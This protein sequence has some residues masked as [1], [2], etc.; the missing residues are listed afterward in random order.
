MRALALLFVASIFAAPSIAQVKGN[1]NLD[2]SQSGT[3]AVAVGL[4]NTA[5]NTAG[6]I[7]GD[8]RISGNTSIKAAQ[9][10]STAVAVGIGTTV[11]N[12]AGVIGGK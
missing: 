11:K 10:G 9:R 4:K 8:A 1:I 5:K 6:S 3:T 12:E 2:A 7:K